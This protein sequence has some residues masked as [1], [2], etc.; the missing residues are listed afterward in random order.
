MA[1]N[2][3]KQVRVH[4]PPDLHKQVRL[5]AAAHETSIAKAVAKLAQ[6]GL[7]ADGVMPES[8][9]EPVHSPPGDYSGAFGY[10]EAPK[11]APKTA[12]KP[13]SAPKIAQK[14]APERPSVGK[15]AVEAVSGAPMA[16]PKPEKRQKR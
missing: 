8:G 7:M 14:P 9:A 2:G 6:W 15:S 4:L 16:F 10:G 13:Q 1:Q 5:F 3:T 11:T 12:P